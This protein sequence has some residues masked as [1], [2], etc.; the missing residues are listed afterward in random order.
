MTK[1]ESAALWRILTVLVG[2]EEIVA[3]EEIEDDL[4]Y[5]LERMP[6]PR[7]LHDVFASEDIDRMLDVLRAEI[8]ANLYYA[9]VGPLVTDVP[10]AERHG[11]T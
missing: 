4:V 8:E 9:D 11:I 1:A 10:G 2:W 5:L 3:V 6:A 7:D